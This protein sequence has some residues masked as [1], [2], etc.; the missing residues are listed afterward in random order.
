MVYKTRPARKSIIDY[1]QLPIAM[2]IERR[3]ELALEV[4]QSSRA[5]AHQLR[6]GAVSLS[7]A[8]VAPLVAHEAYGKQQIA[9]LVGLWDRLAG[10][11]RVEE[12]N[13][14]PKRVL[15]DATRV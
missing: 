1:R 10:R 13:Q 11:A 8:G 2:T 4:L 14:M 9:V 6:E 12:P 5:V 3:D 15:E 7:D